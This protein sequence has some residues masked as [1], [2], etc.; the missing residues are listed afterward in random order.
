MSFKF[1]LEWSTPM[2]VPAAVVGLVTIVF[3]LIIWSTAPENIPDLPGPRGWPIVGSLFQRGSDSADTYHRWSKI[4][5]PVFRVRLGYKWVV[6]INSADAADELLASSAYAAVFQSRPVPYSMRKLWD[7]TSHKTITI[8]SSPYDDLLKGKRRLS[9]AS[10]SPAASKS[11]ENII[12]RSTQ[13]FV[14]DLNNAMKRGGPIDPS[15]IFFKNSACLAIGIFFGTS[16]DEASHLFDDIPYPMKRMA[17]IRDINGKA[18]DYLPFLR[19]FPSGEIFRQAVAVAQYR[20]DKFTGLLDKCRQRFAAGT[21]EPCAAVTIMKDHKTELTDEALTSVSNSMVSSGLESHMPN[22]LLWSLG[23]LASNKSIQEKCYQAVV[24]RAALHDSVDFEKDRDD[25]LMAF[26]K[27]AGRYFTTLRL[28]VARETIGKDCVWQGHY[29]P[30]GTTVWCNS[31]AI[32]RDESRFQLPESFIPERYMNG[33]EAERSMPHYSFGIGR[34]MCPATILVHKENYAIFQT[35]LTHYS[36]ELFDGEREFDP[37][38][39]CADSRQFSQ[40]PKP[41]RIKLEVRDSKK[42]ETFLK[43]TF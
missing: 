37:V 26:V 32:N 43:T 4:Y 16:I 1:V 38:R 35:I 34:R 3:G 28:S 2:L 8:G 9:I 7:Q 40:G 13:N 29:I 42:L 10:V 24:R 18:K 19:I 12:H 33:P 21:A 30:K 39:G 17:Q 27:E 14:R 25:Y 6:V 41:Y 20:N 31:H 22:L 11:Y 5:G 23:L 36:V 15:P